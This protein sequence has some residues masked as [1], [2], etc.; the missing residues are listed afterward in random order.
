[1]SSRAFSLIESSVVL[2]IIGLLVA[3]ITGGASLIESAKIRALTNEIVDLKTNALIFKSIHDRL[4]GDINKDGL[5]DLDEYKVYGSSDFKFPYDNTDNINNHYPP[6][7]WSAPFVEL[8]LEK[9]ISFEP[10]GRPETDSKKNIQGRGT[11]NNGGMPF[12]K[13][14]PNYF[15]GLDYWK[16]TVSPEYY[17]YGFYNTNYLFIQSYDDK[18]AVKSKIFFKLDLKIDDGVFN[19][20][21]IRSYCTNDNLIQG[22]YMP[23]NQGIKAVCPKLINRID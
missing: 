5:I 22:G 23:Y 2:I 1:M 18:K 13:G 10:T 19:T 17:S 21:Y 4:P 20:G 15:L 12:S 14:F 11:A 16:N 7:S 8:Y 3:G 9:I 6:D